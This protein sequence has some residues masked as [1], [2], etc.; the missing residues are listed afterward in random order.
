MTQNNL[1]NALWR[2]GER[3][4]GTAR[5][6]EAVAAY[7]EALKE[8][9]RERVAAAMGHGPRTISALRCGGS[10][11]ARAARRGSDEAV[12]AYR[13]ALKEWTRERV[14]L[15]WA[16]TQNN[17]G[18]ALSRLGERE[19]GT[20]RAGGGGCGLSRSPEGNARA[21]ACRSTGR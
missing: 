5:L 3:E 21:S 12:A 8:I 7:R 1:G 18:N 2:L 6:E 16:M 13:E 9:T 15:H 14:P 20:A 19:S 17:L 10:A 4:S 11:S